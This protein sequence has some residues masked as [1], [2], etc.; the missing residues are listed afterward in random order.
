M[1]LNNV[2]DKANSF[3]LSVGVANF[4][5]S[6]FLGLSMKFVWNLLATLQIL[7]HLS[8]IDISIPVDVTNIFASLKDIANLNIIPDDIMQEYVYRKIGF[9]G[10]DLDT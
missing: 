3:M 5:I 1:L 2:S 7:V 6:L 8:L 4:L 9:T 10:L